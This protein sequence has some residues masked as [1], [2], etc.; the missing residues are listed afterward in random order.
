MGL[1]NERFLDWKE[2]NEGPVDIQVSEPLAGGMGERVVL[3]N[4]SESL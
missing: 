4:I 2:Q 3:P 1:M